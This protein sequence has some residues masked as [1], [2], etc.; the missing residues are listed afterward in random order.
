MRCSGLGLGCALHVNK[1][2]WVR[3]RCP[4]C[5]P[6]RRPVTHLWLQPDCNPNAHGAGTGKAEYKSAVLGKGLPA[7]PGAAVG[8]IVFTADEAEKWHAEGEKVGGMEGCSVCFVCAVTC[9]CWEWQRC[10]QS[11]D[12][13][14]AM[15]NLP[16][17]GFHPLQ[18]ILLRVETSPE[19]VGGMHAAEVSKGR[20]TG[21]QP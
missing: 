7:S 16:C 20:C 12:A 18:V 1:P 13:M 15:L 4:L 10:G 5:L 2:G 21:L 17:A 19:D 9:R 11:R 3:Q 8:R 14:D 6:P